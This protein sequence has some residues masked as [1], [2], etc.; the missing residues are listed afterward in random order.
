[1]A[2]RGVGAGLTCHLRMGGRLRSPGGDWRPS[3]VRGAKGETFGGWIVGEWVRCRYECD[4]NSS[5]GC[6]VC[7][8][9]CLR[10]A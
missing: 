3:G 7:L 6:V 5:R 1:M 4:A 10:F 8:V 2:A 9:V